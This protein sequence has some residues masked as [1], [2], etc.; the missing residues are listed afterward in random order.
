MGETV[1]E[2]VGVTERAGNAKP[3][4]TAICLAPEVHTTVSSE[5]P[6]SGEQRLRV[7]HSG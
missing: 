7:S 1:C 3:E 4:N 5:V 6:V 2:C